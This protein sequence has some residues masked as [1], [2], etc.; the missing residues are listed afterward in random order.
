MLLIEW[1][2][3]LLA[4]AT[5]LYASI[6]DPVA[7]S[8]LVSHPGANHLCGLGTDAAYSLREVTDTVNYLLGGIHGSLRILQCLLKKG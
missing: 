6:R 1:L 2:K 4:V 5:V 3:V 8:N 7:R